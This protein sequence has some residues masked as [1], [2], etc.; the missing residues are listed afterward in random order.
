VVNNDNVVIA[1]KFADGSVGSVTYSGTGD[2]AYSREA[3]EIFFEGKTI[4]SRDLRV[5]ELHGKGKTVVFK[6]RG[7]EMGY[8]EEL[9]HFISCVAGKETLLVSPEEMFATMKTIFAIEK[10]LATANAVSLEKS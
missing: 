6:T 5:C 1:L 3:L 10:S 4:V 7:Q 2:K 8:V 9:K